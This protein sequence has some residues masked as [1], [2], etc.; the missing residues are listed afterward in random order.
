[1]I[2]LAKPKKTRDA[3]NLDIYIKEEKRRSYA[4]YAKAASFFSLPYYSLVRIAKE[5]GACLQI[6]RA[7][8]VDL[9][10]LE[11]YIE[12]NCKG[13][14]QDGLQEEDDGVGG[15]QGTDS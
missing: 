7:V 9:D 3:L 13:S 12:N 11:G 2:R 14:E 1:M 10:K 4:T 5:A 15:D 8:I 6:R